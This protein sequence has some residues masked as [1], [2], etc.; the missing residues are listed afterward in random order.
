MSRAAAT[1]CPLVLAGMAVALAGAEVVRLPMDGGVPVRRDAAAAYARQAADVPAAAAGRPVLAGAYVWNGRADREYRPF[2]Q[3]ELRLRTAGAELRDAEVRVATLGRR[4]EVLAQGPWQPIGEIA[5]ERDLALLLHC[6]VFPAYQIEVRWAGAAAPRCFIASDR[7]ALPRPL[8]E[9]AG[10]SWLA[11]VGA[12]A[13]RDDRRRVA[14]VT[15][16]LWNLG[17]APGR[18]VV[19]TFRLRDGAGAEVKRATWSP[20]RGE[21]LPGYAQEHRLVMEKTPDFAAL[22]VDVR[23]DLPAAVEPDGPP[24]AD[25]EVRAL[26]LEGGVLHGE[27]R[28]GL[29]QDLRALRIELAMRGADKALHRLSAVVGDL[30]A[31][32]SRSFAAPAPGLAALG[33]YELN[34]ATAAP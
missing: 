26:R 6:A 28:N 18:G 24:A 12:D 1:C 7:L 15:W 25:V 9:A 16:A 13:E 14:T 10:R 20:P 8:D 22:A 27:V 4:R 30:P 3:W 23:E 34:W 5:G 32:A 33:P 11:V 2:H 19:L 17:G 21:L 31:G 29:G